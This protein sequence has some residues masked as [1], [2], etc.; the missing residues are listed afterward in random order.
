MD[1]DIKEIFTYL[2]SDKDSRVSLSDIERVCRTIGLEFNIKDYE[3]LLG[4][5]NPSLISSMSFEEFKQLMEKKVYKDM[6]QD[7]L[8]KSFKVFDKN[9]TGR[10]NTAEF[11]QVMNQVVE[12]NKILTKDEVAEFIKIADPKNDG[13]FNYNVFIKTLQ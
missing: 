13:V 11:H 8:L 6:S 2:D 12:E 3:K 1:K 9:N 4:S 5:I 10:I 7:D